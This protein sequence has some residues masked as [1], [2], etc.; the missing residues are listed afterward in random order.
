MTNQ[1]IC[2]DRIKL[3]QKVHE[4]LSSLRIDIEGLDDD[5]HYDSLLIALDQILALIPD[6]EVNNE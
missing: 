2:T 6:K 4:I 5:F 1:P 3:R